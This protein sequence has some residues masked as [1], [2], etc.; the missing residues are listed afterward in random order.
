MTTGTNK[1][2]KRVWAFPTL[3]ASLL[4][5]ILFH[6]LTSSSH[7]SIRSIEGITIKVADG[8]TVT[9]L[10]LEDTKLRVRLQGIDAPEIQ[11]GRQPGQPYGVEAKRALWEKVLG[12]QV[13]LEIHDIDRYKRVVGI[14]RIGSRNIN[15][16][17]V[18]EGC[19]WA[20]RE[21]MKGPYAS[22]FIL[23]ERR[24]REKRLGLWRQYNPQPPWEFRRQSRKR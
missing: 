22:D 14:L 1:P 8:D 3:A 13:I 5:I 17:M 23:V 2:K 15:E 24:A 6:D 11:H 12:Q 16:E 21:Y 18:V 7:A 19:A 10:T 9:V 4:A 20:Y